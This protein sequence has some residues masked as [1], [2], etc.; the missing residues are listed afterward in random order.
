M[1]V[2]AMTCVGE[3]WTINRPD[4]KKF[5]RSVAGYVLLDQKWSIDIGSEFKIFNLVERTEKQKEN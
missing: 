4:I 1:A 2:P 3:N 5:L